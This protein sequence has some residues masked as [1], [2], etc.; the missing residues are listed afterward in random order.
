MVGVGTARRRR[1]RKKRIMKGGG[2]K[3]GNIKLFTSGLANAFRPGGIKR[4]SKAEI[5]LLKKFN[6]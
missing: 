4:M 3:L 2:L 5:A 1:Q 6:R